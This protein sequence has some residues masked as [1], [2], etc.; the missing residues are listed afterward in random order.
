[1]KLTGGWHMNPISLPVSQDA[2]VTEARTLVVCGRA[3]AIY[4]ALFGMLLGLVTFLVW[5]RTTD[6]LELIQAFAFT[7]AYGAVLGAPSG[8]LGGVV[9][10]AMGG[11]VGAL[12]GGF[13]AALS[14]PLGFNYLWQTATGTGNVGQSLAGDALGWAPFLLAPLA[15][16]GL[17]AAMGRGFRWPMLE[18]VRRTLRCSVLTGWR[19]VHRVALGAATATLL[20][21][22]VIGIWVLFIFA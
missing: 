16:W 15:G 10:G 5:E 14:S 22:V 13:T 6:P 7:A 9:Y 3:G 2:E 20:T 4:G 18:A 12:L 17:H 8:F 21:V 1:M 11:R 19:P